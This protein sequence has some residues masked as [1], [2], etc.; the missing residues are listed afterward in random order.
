MVPFISTLWNWI[1]DASNLIVPQRCAVCG[2]RLHKYEEQICIKCFSTLPLT[3]IRGKKGNKVEQIFWGKIPICRANSFMHYLPQAETSHI[4]TRLKYKNRPQIGV[5]FGEIMAEDLIDTDFFDDIDL[6][7]PLPLAKERLRKRGYNQSEALAI[8]VNHIT[9]IP[10]DNT[11]VIRVISNPSQT[12][13]KKSERAE[14]VKNIF[15][16]S[17][18]QQLDRKHV[19]LIDDILTTGA[20]LL[21]CSQEIAKAESVKISILTLGIAGLHFAISRDRM[22]E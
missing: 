13:K 2:H 15:A 10:I 20:T 3:H 6:I 21:S 11:S 22:H 19:L 17:P 8:G 7:I 4:F 5:K 9:H 16:L 14:N 18:H 12:T 1:N